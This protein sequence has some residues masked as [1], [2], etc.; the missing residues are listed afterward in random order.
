M[1]EFDAMLEKG[2]NLLSKEKDVLDLSVHNPTN[3]A[4]IE[5]KHKNDM[6]MA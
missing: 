5:M 3:K 6:A 1:H 2:V 4:K